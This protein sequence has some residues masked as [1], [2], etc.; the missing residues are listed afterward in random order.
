MTRFSFLWVFFFLLFAPPAKAEFIHAVKPGESLSSIA[1]K[2]HRSVAQVQ[3]A[4]ELDGE[5]LH[6]GQRLVTAAG[7]SLPVN[8]PEGGVEVETNIQEP[9]GKKIEAGAEVPKAQASK[10]GFLVEEKEGQLLVRVAR[11]FLGLK[12]RRGGT[13]INGMDCSAFVQKVFQIFGIDLPR[14]VREQFQ[15]G[16]EVAREAIQTGDLVFFKRG[17]TPRPTHVG[18]YIGDGQFIHTSL[19]KQRVEIDSLE[20]RYFS[21]RFVGA[22]RIEEKMGGDLP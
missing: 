21:V 11:G 20:S 19:G 3:E 17:K 4:N 8:L 16:F 15:V 6:P 10:Y 12:Y 5:K 9:E 14:T 18:I 13:G 1:K 7:H 22:K 2:F